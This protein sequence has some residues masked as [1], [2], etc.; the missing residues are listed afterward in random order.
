MTVNPAELQ[1]HL[2]DYAE[3]CGERKSRFVCPITLRECDESE[4]INGHILNKAIRKA[5]RKTVIQFKGVDGHY[6]HTVEPHFVRYLNSRH[7]T[8]LEWVADSDDLKLEFHDGTKADAFHAVSRSARKAVVKF[9]LVDVPIS[10]GTAPVFVKVAKDDPRL[11]MPMKL[12]V[13]DWHY[14]AHWVASMVKAGY[15][16]LFR[17]IGYRA[18]F[19]A[20]GDTVRYSLKR[21]YA[22]G[23]RREQ[24]RHYF[25]EYRNAVKLLGMG[26][27]PEDLHDAYRPFEFDTLEDQE[28]FLH[29]TPADTLFAATC[30]FRVNET[31][32]T[33]TLPQR[34]SQAD[35]AIAFEFYGRLMA[36]DR[37]VQQKGKCKRARFKNQQWDVDKS[38]TRVHY[39]DDSED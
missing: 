32:V 3:V 7:K 10:E 17:M 38:E 18:V 19:D 9:P 39:L 35:P 15:L 26:S 34:T 2:D 27:K 20:F 1:R 16:A 30:I 28:L 37:V 21:F 4:L 29:Y 11:K 31:T 13:T 23:A 22:E 24:A 12:A 5:S 33:V 8:A 25:Y 6:G 36:H 14:P